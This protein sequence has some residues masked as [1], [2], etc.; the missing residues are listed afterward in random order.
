[1]HVFAVLWH[2]QQPCCDSFGNASLKLLK[3]P[4]GLELCPKWVS[5]EWCEGELKGSDV[6][7]DGEE[8]ED[9]EDSDDNSDL[10]VLA[11]VSC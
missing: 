7:K 1:M 2:A 11:W 5:Y 9:R 3:L 4:K 8:A 10:S 6:L